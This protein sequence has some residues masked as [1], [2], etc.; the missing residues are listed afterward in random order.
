VCANFDSLDLSAL[1][2]IPDILPL[3]LSDDRL[4][5]Q[6]EDHLLEI[7]ESILRQNSSLLFV[8]DFIEAQ[9]LSV[10]GITRFI[11]LISQES[12][13]SAVWSSLIRRL[14]LPVSP[15]NPNPRLSLN[16]PLD[17]SRPFESVFHHLWQQC[18]GN[19]HSAGRIHISA[20]DER[21]NC[22]FPCH[23]LISPESKSGKYWATGNSAVDHFLKIDFK[24]RRLRPSAYSVKVHNSS[25]GR[26]HFLKSWRFEG[27]NDDSTSAAL[28]RRTDSEELCGNDREVSFEF[29][30]A[31]SVA[32]RFV[33]F[34]MDG[35][36][37]S[38]D[39]QFSMQRFEVFGLVIV[40]TP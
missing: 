4:R 20:N 29:S 19:P 2:Q 21:S 15:K 12:L 33:R 38:G 18:G 27:S 23:D 40:N 39:H 26:S 16:Y 11:S 35:K 25:W 36:N 10:E 8:L 32:F 3:L 24:D 30:P 6:S 14:S 31:S 17:R 5:I 28:D 13:S 1:S 9:F 7:T 37:S 22:T 34:V